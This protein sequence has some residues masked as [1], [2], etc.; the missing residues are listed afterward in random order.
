MKKIVLVI[1]SAFLMSAAVPAFALT[2]QER[3]ICAMS[4]G[5]CLDEAKILE[6]RIME[7]K[8]EIEKS[9]NGSPKEAKKL[10]K[11]LQDTMDELKSVE[12]EI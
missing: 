11:K 8:K 1:M 3:V 12:D 7:I 5:N 9:A 10:E 6:K 4:A 2:H